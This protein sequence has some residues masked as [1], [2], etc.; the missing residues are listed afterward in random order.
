[1]PNDAKRR[2]PRTS[3]CLRF[4]RFGNQHII[5]DVRTLAGGNPVAR[6]RWIGGLVIAVCSSVLQAQIA[7]G[8]AARGQAQGDPSRGRRL[9]ARKCAGCHSNG[10]AT[11]ISNERKVAPPSFLTLLWNHGPAMRA[12]MSRKG[13][14]WPRLSG[15]EMADLSAY[16]ARRRSSEASEIAGGS[17]GIDRPSRIHDH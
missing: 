17:A 9:F 12:A 16:L 15:A 10:A 14:A 13:L 3:G 4:C 7:P 11:L 6:L 8:D 1:M 2:L 5:R